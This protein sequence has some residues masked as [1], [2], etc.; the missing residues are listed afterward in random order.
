[1][2][3]FPAASSSR[4]ER[5]GRSKLQI[6][7]VDGG[8]AQA[9]AGRQVPEVAHGQIC[10]SSRAVDGGG[11]WQGTVVL[12]QA[13]WGEAGSGQQRRSRLFFFSPGRRRA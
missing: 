10:L 13:R 9:R 5:P 1:M 11:T 12:G 7:R 8:P 2:P 6:A 3:L 4:C